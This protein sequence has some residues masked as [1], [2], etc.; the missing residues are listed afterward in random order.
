MD[1]AG[2]FHS[3]NHLVGRQRELSP[4]VKISGDVQHQGWRQ[5]YLAGSRRTP[6]GVIVGEVREE[7]AK[8]APPRSIAESSRQFRKHGVLAARYLRPETYEATGRFR[9]TSRPLQQLCLERFFL[10]R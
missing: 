6:C 9:N 7:G 5:Y 3:Q 4:Q 8:V 2:N 1:L 10:L